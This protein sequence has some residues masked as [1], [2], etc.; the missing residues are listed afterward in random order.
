MKILYILDCKLDVIGGSQKSTITTMNGMLEKKCDVTLYSQYPNNVKSDVFNSSIKY[1]FFKKRKNN[2]LNALYKMFHFKKFFAH[3]DYN[4]VHVQNT[5]FFVI[6]GILLKFK[7]IKRK[8]TKFV[9]TDRDFY[10]AYT[11]RY[12]KLISFVANE[13]DY[14]YCTTSLN[15]NEWKKMN[16]NVKVISNS[17]E[18]YWF[19]YDEALEKDLRVKNNVD[20]KFVIGFCGRFVAY[21]RWDNVYKICKKLYKYKDICFVFSISTSNDVEEQEYNK[22]KEELYALNG[23]NVT[24]YKNANLELMTKF[25]YILNIFVLT[26]DKESFGRTLI[27]AMTKKNVVFGTNSGGVPEVVPTRKYLFEVNDID[28][29]VKKILEIK[30]N[31]KLELECEQELFDFCRKHYKSEKMID[32]YYDSYL[33][34][35]NNVGESK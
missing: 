28:S 12:Q 31:K 19:D 1:V 17:L 6:L 21:K 11:K 33:K 34:V 16:N 22:F 15:A 7:L 23:I 29:I 10:I 24:F 9:Y 27:E 18:N 2:Y 30:S 26:S 14:I 25:Y 20:D 5:R 32:E 3:N 35:L 13:Y 8:N 4:V